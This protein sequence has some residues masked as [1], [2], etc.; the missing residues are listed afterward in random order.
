MEDRLITV[1]TARL[2]HSKGFNWIDKRNT[3]YHRIYDTTGEIVKVGIKL[4]TSWIEC[5]K[6]NP[7][8]TR[9][10]YLALVPTQSF[11]SKWLRELPTPIIVVPSTDFIAWD[12]KI[13][14]PD[15]GAMYIDKNAEGR[16]FN[17]YEEAFKAGL[18]QALNLI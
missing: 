14:H 10:N 18:V 7:T 9:Y 15:K 17:S 11:L 4:L 6:A 13:Y 3:S 12:V 2:A 1:E 16:W 8:D 5:W